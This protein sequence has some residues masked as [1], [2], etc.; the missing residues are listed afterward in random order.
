[1]FRLKVRKEVTREGKFLQ[2]HAFLGLGLRSRSGIENGTEERE[3]RE[4]TLTAELDC[5]A[6]RIP[7][8]G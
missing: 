5:S 1:M 4:K 6:G 7:H 3:R 2:D 8:T